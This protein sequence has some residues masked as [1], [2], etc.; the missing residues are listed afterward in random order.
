MPPGMTCL[1]QLTGDHK[2]PFQEWA[3]LDLRYIDNWSVW[4]DV[5]LILATLLIIFRRPGW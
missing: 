4:L 2:M 3:A 1:W 5:K